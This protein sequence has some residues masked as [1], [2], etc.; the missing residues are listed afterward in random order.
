M[1][2]GRMLNKKISLNNKVAKLINELGGDAGLIYTW[3]IAHLDRDGRISGDPEVIW[4]QVTP[5]LTRSTPD[6]VWATLA[7]AHELKLLIIYQTDEGDL[8]VEYPKFAQNQQ[9]MR[10]D[11]EAVSEFPANSGLTPD[12]VRSTPDL[13]RR[14]PAEVNGME[15]KRREVNTRENNNADNAK[16]RLA[17]EKKKHQK[18]DIKAV[19]SYY[20]QVNRSARTPK[21]G[22]E[23]WRRI[24]AR[25]SE[26]TPEDL[27]RAIDGCWADPWYAEKGK[28]DLA[29]I[30]QSE[31][32]VLEMIGKFESQQNPKAQQQQQQFGWH[33]GSKASE[34]GDGLQKL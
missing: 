12:L 33:P 16:L 2:R 15:E 13:L 3:I 10:Y 20:K 28:Q 9:G 21:E 29:F 30:C 11:R 7:K 1:A 14:P 31:A 5:L 6:L 25:L 27:R 23:T 17:D 24:K 19:I 4:A 26:F 32:R 34:F 8:V 22:K 18:E